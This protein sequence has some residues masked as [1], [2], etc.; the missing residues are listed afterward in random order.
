MSQNGL[1][2]KDAIFVIVPL[3]GSLTR[4]EHV[5]NA[6]VTTP[7]LFIVHDD[8]SK[9]AWSIVDIFRDVEDELYVFNSLL[10]R[11][12]LISMLRKELS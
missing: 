1:D 7:A 3:K 2:R 12:N 8:I 11:L 4:H 10:F 6:R 5:A 9:A